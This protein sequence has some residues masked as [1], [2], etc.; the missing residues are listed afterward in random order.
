ML[1]DLRGSLWNKWDLHVHTPASI[2]QHYG[3]DNDSWEKFF[4]SIEALPEEFKVIG[5]N[6]YILI[7]G[8]K[9]VTKAHS[10]GRDAKYRIILACC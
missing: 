6:D 3:R 1:N 9:E 4:S 10:Q 2:I 8:Y 5:I 7:D